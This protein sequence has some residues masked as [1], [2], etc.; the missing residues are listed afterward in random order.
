MDYYV[1]GELVHGSWRNDDYENRTSLLDLRNVAR[2]LPLVAKEI[3]EELADYFL[4]E[5]QVSW[6]NDYN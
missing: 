6:Q 1:N 3:R 5:G 4:N 2:R